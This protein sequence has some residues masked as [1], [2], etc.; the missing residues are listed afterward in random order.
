[1]KYYWTPVYDILKLFNINAITIF[2]V[3]NEKHLRLQLFN[4]WLLHKMGTLYL[5]HSLLKQSTRTHIPGFQN[6]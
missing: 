6:L 4:T 2:V 5:S 3:Q 1:M